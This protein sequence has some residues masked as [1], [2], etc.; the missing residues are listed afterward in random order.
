MSKNVKQTDNI[1]LSF[2][3]AFWMYYMLQR[4]FRLVKGAK[5]GTDLGQSIRKDDV[6]MQLS[7][8]RVSVISLRVIIRFLIFISNL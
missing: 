1:H 4:S 5:C 2:S 6:N 3:K 8:F 7:N